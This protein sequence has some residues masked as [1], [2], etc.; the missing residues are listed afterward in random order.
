MIDCLGNGGGLPNSGECESF[1][2]QDSVTVADS[3]KVPTA[4]NIPK[5]IVGYGGGES[6]GV[7][8][9]EAVP[10][11]DRSMKS[12]AYPSMLFLEEDDN[13]TDLSHLMDE[14]LTQ[15]FFNKF[16]NIDLLSTGDDE[17]ITILLKLVECNRVDILKLMPG[18]LFQRKSRFSGILHR[19]AELGYLE[20]VKLL[21]G[22]APELLELYAGYGRSESPICLAAA[23]GHIDCL[24][25]LC[26]TFGNDYNRRF[27]FEKKN[28]LQY[29]AQGGHLECMEFLSDK[30]PDL[31]KQEDR[32]E[33]NSLHY[34]I[35]G[36]GADSLNCLLTLIGK[37]P[38]G[39]WQKECMENNGLVAAALKYRNVKI[40]AYLLEFDL[41]RRPLSCTKEFSKCIRAL[42]DGTL[43]PLD[44]ECIRI[45]DKALKKFD[46][47]ATEPEL[48]G[49]NRKNY[50]D[51][52]RR[53]TYQGFA[54]RK[55]GSDCK[56]AGRNLVQAVER[57]NL[58]SAASV[59][60]LG[61]AKA[62]LAGFDNVGVFSEIDVFPGEKAGKY[63]SQGDLNAE[64]RVLEVLAGL[65]VKNINYMVSALGELSV[66]SAKLSD[67]IGAMVEVEKQGQKIRKGGTTITIIPVGSCAARSRSVSSPVIFSFSDFYTVEKT[68]SHISKNYICIKPY[69]FASAAAS[70]WIAIRDNP[71]RGRPILQNLPVNAVIPN[72]VNHSSGIEYLDLAGKTSTEPELSAEPG[73]AIN[74]GITLC[75]KRKENRL[76]I[77]MV[78]GLHHLDVGGADRKKMLTTWVKAIQE[79]LASST[80]KC[81]VMVTLVSNMMGSD[82]LE[83]LEGSTGV[84][85]F[86]FAGKTDKQV[87]DWL[88]G[89]SSGEV[90]LGVMPSL[91]R[92]VFDQLVNSSDY[93][94]LVEG[95][96]L[97]SHVIQRGHPHLSVLP[98]G[99]TP[100]SLDMGN[101]LEA[102]KA[103]AFSY[104][105]NLSER[106]EQALNAL[107]G[108]IINKKYKEGLDLVEKLSGDSDHEQ[109]SFLWGQ[110][111]KGQHPKSKSFITVQS[112]LERGEILA[113]QNRSLGEIGFSA[114]KSAVDPSV[115]ALA[116]YLNDCLDDKSPTCHH[117]ALQQHH[118]RQPFNDAVTQSLVAFGKQMG[119]LQ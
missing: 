17:L 107:L 113:E 62:L 53:K 67:Q 14:F 98:Q 27:G 95:A 74:A 78:Y 8:S 63:Y 91:P 5:Q 116:S 79:K 110:L 61:Q 32:F 60:S 89:L 55:P 3:K 66:A 105:L 72:N 77:S 31:I 28:I 85:C 19:A 94:V 109:L 51:Q 56:E 10:V 30:Y 75:A 1:G 47:L 43:G 76:H 9:V 29:A 71:E 42:V 101:P 81:P 83:S 39:V 96:N 49:F 69:H 93:P 106:S 119:L 84:R 15:N 73:A 25:F 88:Q 46:L 16:K 80:D 115:A 24:R 111:N 97:T 104:K 103:Q 41:H 90:V 68:C 45:F 50:R 21:V 87:T 36:K 22:K 35:M 44:M 7:A 65:G 100:V 54:Y 40:L 102:M 86:G 114:L 2:K 18:I 52:Y 12:V 13:K 48:T 26:D 4:L 112:L 59:D 117:F 34:A 57:H 92:P 70:M 82:A 38:A 20:C 37:Y 58:D 99:K 23:N 108:F 64:V 11:G 6:A 118:V 33:Q